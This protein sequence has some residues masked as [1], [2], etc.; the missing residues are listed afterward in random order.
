MNPMH[1]RVVQP[2]TAGLRAVSSALATE[3]DRFFVAFR[4][5]LPHFFSLMVGL[6]SI[7][8]S[9]A[10][11]FIIRVDSGLSIINN[12]SNNHDIIAKISF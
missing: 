5:G 12:F 7:S 6:T 8:G 9:S 2:A 11:S 10:S 3:N 1:D 4:P